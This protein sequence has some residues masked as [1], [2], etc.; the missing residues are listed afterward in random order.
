MFTSKPFRINTYEKR[1]QVLILIHLITYLSC[2]K[3]TLTEKGEGGPSHTGV[4]GHAG[5]VSNLEPLRSKFQ[6]LRQLQWPWDSES[7][8]D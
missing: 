5:L 4:G 2:L 1:S 7:P 3:S 6:N 8:C